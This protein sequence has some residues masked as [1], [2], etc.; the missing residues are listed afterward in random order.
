MDAPRIVQVPSYRVDRVGPYSARLV[1]Y[2]CDE[3]SDAERKGL[4]AWLR[5]RADDVKSCGK[6]MSKVFSAKWR[7][8]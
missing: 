2:G 7:C 8:R 4:E 5:R 6:N 3:L 1:I